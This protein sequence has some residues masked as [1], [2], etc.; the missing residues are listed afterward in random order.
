LR[1]VV[2]VYVLRARRAFVDPKHVTPHDIHAMLAR[3]VESYFDIVEK[4]GT[5]SVTEVLACLRS[6]EATRLARFR[7]ITIVG[8]R[9]REVAKCLGIDYGDCSYLVLRVATPS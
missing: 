2:E 4:V 6:D 8:D 3:H 1:M 7:E 5:R 9:A